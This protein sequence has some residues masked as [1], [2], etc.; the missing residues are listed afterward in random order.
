MANLFGSGVSGLL[1]SQRAIA[2]TGH[3]ISNV[4]TEGYSRQQ[5]ETST[6]IAQPSGAGYLGSGVKVDNVRR[7]YD[8]F[9]TEQ[10]RTH[11]SQDGY[12]NKFHDLASQV[13][14]LLADPDAGLDPA[15]QQ[16]F[17]SLNGLADNP[18]STSA[19]QVVLSEAESLT[20]RFHSVDGRLAS[21]EESA[22]SRLENIVGE[23]NAIADSIAEVNKNIGLA[24]DLAGGSPP[25]DLLD[26]R[27]ELLRK[28]SE[29]VPVSTVEQEDG[30]VNVFVGNG[31]TLVLNDD[32]QGLGIARSAY[33]NSRYEVTAGRS[34][35][36]PVISKQLKGGEIAG[37]LDFRSEVLD[38]TRNKLGRIAA[39]LAQS[40][41]D[42]HKLGMDL[43]NELG[44][45]FFS[46]N[47]LGEFSTTGTYRYEVNANQAELEFRI[48]D[49]SQ[50]TA[51][52][53]RVEY[54]GSDYEVTRLSDHTVVDVTES[55]GV[56]TTED[57][58]SF[59][60]G[61]GSPVAGDRFLITP[62]REGSK[63]IERAV[64][65]VK[66]IAAALPIR[67]E[68]DAGNLGGAELNS[69]EVGAGTELPTVFNEGPITLAFDEGNDRFNVAT[70][71]GPSGT[72]PYDPSTQS[73][74]DFDL[75]S[76]LGA[77]YDDIKFRISG[78]PLDGDTFTIEKNN[79][80]VSDNRNALK[81]AELQETGVLEN[82]TTTFQ[83]S[84]GQMVSEVGTRT[85]QL[86]I[87]SESQKTLLKQ[88]VATREGISGVNLDEE[89][90][91]LTR[92][93]QAYQASAQVISA[94]QSMF[95][96]LLSAVR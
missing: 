21:L 96:T 73:S 13:D 93:Q 14:N 51:S 41:N 2:T 92:Y 55:G 23:I 71:S 75:G 61:S 49:A 66:S 58:F 90:A 48:D 18:S 84:Y 80:A 88:A 15:V 83:A 6:R 62:T 9:V 68:M 86:D 28:L 94:A 27:D 76:A 45:E 3:N 7:M 20:E 69:L 42:Q 25:N 87:N 60:V 63:S 52:D 17:N 11:T 19:R 38:P 37:V 59:Q 12:L 10:V 26:Q 64:D 89:A 44:E 22:N 56:Y 74:A 29:Y 4:N 54:D 43:N 16:F 35:D 34:G 78:T 85:H 39:G 79:D 36:G 46:L 95:D 8:Q 81:L 47:G 33:D 72:L 5:V 91:D 24:R 40:M 1:A 77:D 65:S 30:A 53:Y 82:E 50:L 31:Q 67:G 32:A 57:G 70:G